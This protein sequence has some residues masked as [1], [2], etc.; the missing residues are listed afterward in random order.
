MN[1][2]TSSGASP[3]R[4]MI[5]N[6]VLLTCA[7]TTGHAQTMGMPGC[8]T[9]PASP[10]T[11][12]DV[13]ATYFGP[14]P[15]SVQKELVGPLQLLTAGKLD[16]KAATLQLPLYKGKVRQG[17]QTVWF[18]LTDTTDRGNA[19]ALGLNFAPKLFYSAVSARSVRTATLLRD[20]SLEFE[21]GTVDFSPD[22]VLT[23][24]PGN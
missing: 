3:A 9:D 6:A 22:R 4:Q 17:N 14:A 8:V 21:A 24:G 12:A 19:E 5:C 1:G 13:P 16:A 7:W 20:G 10:A 23:P 11:G 15:S 18:I 2:I